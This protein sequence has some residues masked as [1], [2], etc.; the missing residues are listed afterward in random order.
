MVLNGNYDRISALGM[1]MLLREDRQKYLDARMSGGSIVTGTG[2][3]FDR[4]FI[5]NSGGT[6]SHRREAWPDQIPGESL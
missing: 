4:Y 2:L 3:Q 1:L 5:K 6:L